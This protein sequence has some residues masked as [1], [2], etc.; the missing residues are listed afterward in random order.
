[1]ETTNQLPVAEA[2]TNAAPDLA[3]DQMSAA[4]PHA[5]AAI[6]TIEVPPLPGR[7]LRSTDE[8]AKSILARKRRIVKDFWEIGQLLIE[9]KN[10]L[11]SHGEWENWLITVVH[12]PP[13]SAERYMKLRS[14]YT[15]PTA[16]SDLCMT[17][18]LA[19]LSLPQEEREDFIS[20]PHQVD[21][22]D[23]RVSEMTTREL[24]QAIKK[25]KSPLDEME[26][27]RYRKSECS[28]EERDFSGEV[29]SI[30]AKAKELT[31]LASKSIEWDKKKGNC[32]D[33][34]KSLHEAVLKC[35][36]IADIQAQ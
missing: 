34:L 20:Q 24:N 25:L 10:Q 36:S 23:K 6:T 30:F 3:P 15:D 8:I 1:M 14:G 33:T 13:R 18:A 31:D 16:L 5:E 32:T 21:G 17:S 4:L 29:Q 7:G 19:I 2:Q 26:I 27:P 11:V 22:Q 9:A 12:M 28:K 35:M